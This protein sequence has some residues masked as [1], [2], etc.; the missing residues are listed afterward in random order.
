MYETFPC[1]LSRG[2]GKAPWVLMAVWEGLTT[3]GE[4]N[5]GDVPVGPSDLRYALT[6]CSA[7][8]CCA[9]RGHSTGSQIFEVAGQRSARRSN[10][11]AIVMERMSEMVTAEGRQSAVAPGFAN[12][13]KETPTG[14]S[15]EGP[16]GRTNRT[17]DRPRP[18]NRGQ[19]SCVRS[20]RFILAVPIR[21]QIGVIVGFVGKVHILACHRRRTVGPLVGARPEDEFVLDG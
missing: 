9:A 14:L 19:G 6:P 17:E 21:R 13:K 18:I 11:P 2:F 1:E 5:A 8:G 4:W 3:P 16:V 20:G 12:Y 10:T 7:A 15:L